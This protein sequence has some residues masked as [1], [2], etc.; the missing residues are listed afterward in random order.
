MSDVDFFKALAT[1]EELNDFKMIVDALVKKHPDNND[2]ILDFLGGLL[3]AMYM[4][5]ARAVFQ[6]ETMKFM[7]LTRNIADGVLPQIGSL[8]EFFRF[9]G[10][11]GKPEK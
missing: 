9:L 8:A 7:V 2:D 1:S 11:G 3:T 6:A 10:K 5:P 4:N